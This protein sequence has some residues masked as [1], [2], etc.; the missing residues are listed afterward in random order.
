MPEVRLQIDDAVARVTLSNPTR[1][2]AMTMAMWTELANAFDA[3]ADDAGVRVV[4][5]AG[6]G[7][8]A[9]VSGADI[10]EF[11]TQ[12]NSA[13][14]VL[15]YEVEGDRARDAMLACSRPVIAAI[16]GVCVGGGLGLAG[17]CDLRY[18][19][20]SSRFRMPVAL[21]LD[22][23]SD[24]RRLA[25]LAAR[26]PT[27]VAAECVTDA[28]AA[29]VDAIVHVVAEGDEVAPWLLR[30]LREKAGAMSIEARLPS[31]TPEAAP[32]TAAAPSARSRKLLRAATEFGAYQ[33]EWFAGIRESVAAGAPFA[34]V[35]ANAPQEILRAFDL[36]FV[37]NQWW[38]SIVAAKRQSDRYRRLLADHDLPDTIEA[39]ST[40]A[41]AAAFDDDPAQAPWSGLPKPDFVFAVASSD[42]THA[43]FDAMAAHYGA[44]SFVYERT[45]D[46]RPV[47][48]TRWW[49]VMPD[50]WDSA[51]E[52]ERID[53]LVDEFRVVIADIEAATG[54]RF[55][56]ARF[57]DIMDLVNEQEDHYRAT[58]DLIARTVPAPVSIVDTM[59]ATMVPQW[60]RGSVWA[61]DAAR[62]FH[63]EVAERVAA[64]LGVVAEEKVRLMWVGR[65]LWSDTAFYQRW[66]DSHGAVFVWSMYLALAADGYI[67]RFDRGRDPLRALA[68]RFLT[69]GDELRMPSWSGPWHVHEAETNQI[70]GAVALADADP[71]TLRALSEAGIPVLELGIDNFARQPGDLDR[72]DARITAFIEGAAGSRAAARCGIAA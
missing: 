31:P 44:R 39:Y 12:R 32:A 27:T 4:V 49:D 57:R 55:D 21:T 38:A 66:E 72:I 19:T 70:D 62:A 34:V 24:P 54:R 33:R 50:Q 35:N 61:R 29:S 6:D 48:E 22:D 26:A 40:Q 14:Q 11:E 71:F 42:P 65:G 63:D 69:M 53:L 23:F 16:R 52:A 36:P 64:G 51:L 47:I 25:P 59:P 18:A 41:L 56:E 17:A 8:K 67:R 15:A 1:H 13:A 9:F 30:P 5:L 2:N 3:I 7:D 10:S 43:I 68:A 28:T 45:V 20:R 46:P 37:V 58:R 60:H